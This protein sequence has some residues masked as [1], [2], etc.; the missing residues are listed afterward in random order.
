[1]QNLCLTQAIQTCDLAGPDIKR[2]KLQH[3]PVDTVKGSTNRF[4]QA[5]TKQHQ[6]SKWEE[7]TQPNHVV[8]QLPEADSSFCLALGGSPEV[9][10]LEPDAGPTAGAAPARCLSTEGHDNSVHPEHW[11]NKAH[12]SAPGSS[13]K[14]PAGATT[15]STNTPE[16]MQSHNSPW[17]QPTHSRTNM[18]ANHTLPKFKVPVLGKHK[19]FKA[20]AMVP[21]H[22]PS[23][24]QLRLSGTQMPHVKAVQAAHTW[25]S[26]SQ[27]AI[28]FCGPVAE[29]AVRH[30][31]IPTSFASLHAYKQAWCAAVT[32]EIN[33]R[34]S[35]AGNISCSLPHAPRH[36]T[37]W[38]WLTVSM[39]IAS[40]VLAGAC[41]DDCQLCLLVPHLA[42]VNGCQECDLV[43]PSKHCADACRLVGLAEDFH[44]AMQHQAQSMQKV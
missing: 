31:V 4:K 15:D 18:Q 12:E 29:P 23:Q 7:F 30:A 14:E 17:Q 27:P 16:K 44:T 34:Y 8:S 3:Q 32:E 41:I 20:P 24:P 33:I 13:G 39:C 42:C 43:G 9:L 40:A 36:G 37:A 19:G 25:Q 35:P 2:K 11:P 38:P 1:M 28:V 26:G 5:Q 21:G 10:T 6:Y 22:H